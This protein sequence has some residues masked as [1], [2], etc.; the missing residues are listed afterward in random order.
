MNFLSLKHLAKLGLKQG[1][2]HKYL[3][4]QKLKNTPRYTPTVTDLFATEIELVDA[5]SF[6]FMY[7]EVFEQQIYRF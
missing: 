6:L 2:R 4:L 3:A 5:A 7:K 1:Y